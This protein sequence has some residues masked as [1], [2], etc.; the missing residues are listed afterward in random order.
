[1]IGRKRVAI[2][3]RYFWPQNYPYASMLKEIAESLVAGGAHVSIYTT[4]S[5]ANGE[6]AIR[7]SWIE[8][9]TVN[10]HSTNLPSE[11]GASILKKTINAI[12]FAFWVSCKL[13]FNKHEVVVVATTPPVVIAFL[14]SVLSKVKG[15]RVVYHC[16]DIHP[17]SLYINNSLSSIFLYKLL[18]YMDFFTIRNAWQVIVLSAD[19]KRTLV[20]RGY[21][22]TN[23][24]VVNNFIFQS[25]KESASPAGIEKS[26]NKVRFIFA[27]SLG[28]FQNLDVLIKGIEKFSSRNDLEFLFLG[29]GPMKAKI[30]LYSQSQGLKNVTF[31]PHVSTVEALKYMSQSD[32][33][34]VSVSAGITKVAYPSKSIMYMSVGLPLLAVLDTDS[35]LSKLLESNGLGVSVEPNVA[36]VEKGINQLVA[37]LKG[38]EFNRTKI[39]A[40]TKDS[41]GKSVILE[42]LNKVILSDS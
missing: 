13:L 12:W 40:F 10:I 25:Y 22:G 5:E 28:R 7:S 8:K 9:S 21:S 34:L 30:Q 19:M 20:D 15:F 4:F 39:K 3:H 16:Q 11:R 41:F 42:K 26:K 23:I 38:K 24:R 29:D 2:V 32:V 6:D 17:E 18:L 35:E 33:G 37:K 14:V 31:I 36:D 1:M 27:G